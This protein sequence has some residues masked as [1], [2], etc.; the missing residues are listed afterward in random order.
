[1]SILLIDHHFITTVGTDVQMLIVETECGGMRF[2]RLFEVS[3]TGFEIS[4]TVDDG[5]GTRSFNEL[6]T[7]RQLI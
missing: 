4:N 6:A 2:P 1:M 5:C 7:Y 3:Q